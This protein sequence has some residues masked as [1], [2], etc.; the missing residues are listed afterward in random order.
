MKVYP[1]CGPCM[2]RQAGEAIDLATDNPKLKIETINEVFKF[3]ASNFKVGASSNKIGS[4][5]HKIVKKKTKCYDPYI[6]EKEMGNLIAIGLF[7]KVE[8]ILKKDDSL[9]NYVKIAI[10]GNILDFGGLGLDIDFEKMI[11][12]SLNKDLAINHIED[13]KNTLENADSLLYLVDNTG[14]IVFDKLLIEKLKEYDLDI[15]VAVKEKPILNDACME[16][17]IAIGLDELTNLVSI[18]TDS[19]GLVYDDLSQEFKEIF[20]SHNFII[21]K[22]LG[23]YEGLTEINLKNK[24]VFYLFSAKCSAIAKDSNVEVNDNVFLKSK[25]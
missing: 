15:T 3:L 7:D 12:E 21:S 18:G 9:E 24:E 25:N 19:V 17:A 13:F 22:G 20:T 2:L 16:D 4:N 8:K 6:K 1:E 10:I 23:N 11:D 5:M 14:E